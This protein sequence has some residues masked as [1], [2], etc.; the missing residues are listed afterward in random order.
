[1][2]WIEAF[3]INSTAFAAENIRLELIVASLFTLIFSAFLNPAIAPPGTLAPM[4]PLIPIMA[5]AGVHP[6]PL[7]LLSAVIGI[8]LSLLKAFPLIMRLSGAGTK[9]GILILF[10]IMGI[11]GSAQKLTDWGL[12]G[13]ALPL[14]IT[15]LIVA[16]TGYAVLYRQGKTWLTIPLSV[17]AG[18][19]LPA[20]FG[21][22]PDFHTSPGLP[23]ID[24]AAWW[25]LHWGIGWG[26]TMTGFLNA[27]PFAV[28]IVV[29][30]PLDA[31][32]ILTMHEHNY[33]PYAQK[34]VFKTDQTFL[35]VSI[36]HL[37]G[38][39]LGGAQIAA[40]WRSFLIPLGVVR[41][42]IPG[43]ALLLGIFG[44]LFGLAGYPIDLAIFPPLLHMVLIL[45]VFLP[46]LLTGIRLKKTKTDWAIA[47]VCILAGYWVN[48][49]LGWLLA[50]VLSLAIARLAVRKK[51]GRL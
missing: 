6:L 8:V 22:F 37:I 10:G 48:P 41:R 25:N 36:R 34:L 16:V 40:V 35:L 31:V 2:A 46:M 7:A 5:A 19:I 12:A 13:G 20:L 15:I 24:P 51:R 18:L 49:L 23:V 4:I 27:L 38:S 14:L 9:S 45:G 33:V 21:I 32:A 42:P 3:G 28:L 43:A 1:M 26:L 44:I 11:A 39:L 29:M 30:W 47:F 17:L 50:V